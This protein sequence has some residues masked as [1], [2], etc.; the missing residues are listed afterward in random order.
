MLL[1]NK[2]DKPADLGS[3][4]GYG[5][6]IIPPMQG[7]T[8]RRIR[9]GGDAG[10]YVVV[11]GQL[12]QRKQPAK[13]VK[14]S[15]DPVGR[16]YIE[17]PEMFRPHCMRMRFRALMRTQNVVFGEEIQNELDNELGRGR[18]ELARIKLQIE[19]EK[20]E[21]R[22]VAM[23]DTPEYK[24]LVDKATEEIAKANARAEAAERRAEAASKPKKRVPQ[25]KKKPPVSSSSN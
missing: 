17:V 3:I 5:D 8:Y 12:E 6:C 25:P 15:D 23:T 16:N 22:P 10:Q 4:G 7:G 14:V 24:E 9:P 13:L 11:E 18:E 19:A 21:A 20:A 1:V 2:G